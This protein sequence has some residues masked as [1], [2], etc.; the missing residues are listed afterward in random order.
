M[1][2]REARQGGRFMRLTMFGIPQTAARLSGDCSKRDNA[3]SA[4][5]FINQAPGICRAV[6]TGVAKHHSKPT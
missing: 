3:I 4:N 6:G 1:P 2:M 5:V